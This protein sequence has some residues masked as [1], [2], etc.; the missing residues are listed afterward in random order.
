MVSPN[1]RR[2]RAVDVDPFI[3]A[4]TRNFGLGR[5]RNM[6]AGKPSFLEKP[7]C[8]RSL[9]VR[10]LNRQLRLFPRFPATGNIPKVI[11]TLPL[12]NARGGARAVTTA[13]INRGGFLLIKLSCP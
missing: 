3:C 4:K 10:S 7:R 13:A 9:A 1:E 11:E 6:M 12:Q 2:A 5:R 8:T